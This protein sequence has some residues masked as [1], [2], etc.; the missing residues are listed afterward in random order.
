[1][2]TKTIATPRGTV[3]VR[4]ATSADAVTLREL[5]LQALQNHPDAFGSDYAREFN[6]PVSYWT[7]RLNNQSSSVI[8]VAATNSNLVGMIGIYHSGLVKLQ[9]NATIWGVYVC[10]EWRSLGIAGQLVESCLEWARAGRLKLVKLAVVT[11]NV[12]AIRS[13]ARC[14][15]RVYGVD[16]QVLQYE[17]VFYDELLMT[18]EV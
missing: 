15:F 2:M 11:T 1:M 3:T 13:Y 18:R 17:G 14:G 12:V 10:P 16:P 6:Q 7:D 8:Y 5:R 9:H 4:Q